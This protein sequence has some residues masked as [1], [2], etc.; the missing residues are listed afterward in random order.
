MIF[1]FIMVDTVMVACINKFEFVELIQY[2]P[3]QRHARMGQRDEY[4]VVDME[5]KFEIQKIK[6]GKSGGNMPNLDY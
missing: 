2:P 3:K 6:V 5:F 4:E 1:G